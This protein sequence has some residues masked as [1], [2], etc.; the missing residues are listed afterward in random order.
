MEYLTVAEAARYIGVAEK[1]IRRWVIAGRLSAYHQ[2]LNRM[3]IPFAQVEYEAL[4]HRRNVPKEFAFIGIPGNLSEL[5]QQMQEL[6]AELRSIPGP[7]LF[8]LGPG[9]MR[10]LEDRMDTIE[11]RLTRIETA[12]C[13]NGEFVSLPT[14]KGTEP[15]L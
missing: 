3:R 6:R 1:T 9:D 4:A 10:Y 11:A 8:A 12:L 15:L 14:Q 2:K 5:T 7:G 13:D